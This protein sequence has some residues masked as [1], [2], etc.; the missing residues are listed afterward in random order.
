MRART[1]SGVCYTETEGRTG[2]EIM[3]PSRLAFYIILALTATAVVLY[4]LAREPE[5]GWPINLVH[6]L[7]SG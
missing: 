3:K 6:L 4:A 2:E 7:C 5:P 1:H